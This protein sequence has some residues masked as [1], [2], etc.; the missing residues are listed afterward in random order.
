MCVH[1]AIVSASVEM[2]VQVLKPTS[3]FSV[4]LFRFYTMCDWDVLQCVDFKI[5]N[6]VS[7]FF[8][9]FLFCLEKVCKRD[10]PNPGRKHILFINAETVHV[11]VLLLADVRS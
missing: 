9:F 6:L 7:I 4:V 2:C 8:S 3:T 5:H 10:S 1:A 11:C